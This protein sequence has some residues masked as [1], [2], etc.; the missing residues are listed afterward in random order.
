MKRFYVWWMVLAAVSFMVAILWIANS[1]DKTNTAQNTPQWFL[2]VQAE[3][4]TASNGTLMLSGLPHDVMLITESPARDT[5][6]MSSTKLTTLWHSFGFDRNPPNAS[7]VGLTPDDEE[8]YEGSIVI[9]G[10]SAE[11]DGGL[12]LEYQLIEGSDPVPAI[13]SNPGVFIDTINCEC[14]TQGCDNCY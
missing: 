6:K 4:A 7:L 10:V 11:D 2:T 9:T 3:S 14:P 12:V 1:C 8:P 13:L 5:K